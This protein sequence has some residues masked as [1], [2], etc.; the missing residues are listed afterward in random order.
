MAELSYKLGLSEEIGAF[1]AGVAL[2]THPISLYI[3]ES[4]K[5][6]RDFFLVMFFFTIGA[7]FHFDFLPVVALPAFVLAGFILIVKPYTFGWL[8]HKSGESKSVGFEI[9]VR[10]GQISEFSLLVIYLALQTKLVSEKASYM[11]QA[12][13]ILT[14]IVSSY[15]VVL[16]YPTPIAASDKL[17][18]D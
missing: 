6:L 12:A 2:A 5:P 17:R 15:W 9:G 4:L 1:I 11:I 13:T 18:R 10:L 16:R 14:F 8:L 3:A 7:G